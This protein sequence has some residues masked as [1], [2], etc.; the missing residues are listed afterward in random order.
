MSH[1]EPEKLTGRKYSQ[2]TYYHTDERRPMIVTARHMASREMLY[3]ASSSGAHYDEREK[4]LKGCENIVEG[5][6]AH[7]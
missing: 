1:P 2:L 7:A 3:C 4:V 6:A 5:I